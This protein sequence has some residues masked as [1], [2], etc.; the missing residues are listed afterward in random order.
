MTS[1]TKDMQSVYK[2]H[3]KKSMQYKACKY[4]L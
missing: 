1:V 2:I 4:K 3:V